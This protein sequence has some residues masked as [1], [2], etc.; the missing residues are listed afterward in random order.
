M[1][2][3]QRGQDDETSEEESSDSD[4]EGQKVEDITMSK[5]QARAARRD[6]RRLKAKQ[7]TLQQEVRN[8]L[9]LK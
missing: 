8:F 7:E 4:E 1:S 9:L 3:A 6:R 5:V 2:A